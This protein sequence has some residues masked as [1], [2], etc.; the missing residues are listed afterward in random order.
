MANW[1]YVENGEVKESYDILPDSWKNISN[2]YAAKDDL[3]Y[4]ASLNWFPII[5]PEYEYDRGTQRLDNRR[6]T[7]VDNQVTEEWD[8]VEIPKLPAP[9]IDDI[10]KM[11]ITTAQQRLDEFAQVKGYNDIL[12]ACS[13][14]VDTNL[15]FQ[16]EGMYCVQK[17]SQTWEALF[18]IIEEIKIGNRVV[19]QQYIDIEHLLPSL[20]WPE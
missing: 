17:R 15:K 19:P 12:A 6:F 16:T 20:V 10:E 7:V 3:E 14:A 18:E 13:Y 4:L 2:F 1:A 11:L 8:I 9:T 5:H